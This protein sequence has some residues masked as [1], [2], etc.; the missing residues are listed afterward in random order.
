MIYYN[1]NDVVRRSDYDQV[2]YENQNLRDAIQKVKSIA[3][4]AQYDI[5]KD[6]FIYNFRE[7]L[8][9]LDGV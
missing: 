5:R 9:I 6:D 7:I 2:M 1:E 3:M 8:L 4:A